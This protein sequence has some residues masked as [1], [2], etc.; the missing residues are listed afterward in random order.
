[1][2]KDKKKSKPA[3]KVQDMKAKKDPKGGAVDM[4][5]KIGGIKGELKAPSMDKI[6]PSALTTNIKYHK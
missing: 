5:L 2:A 4:Y 3:V 1:M 6:A